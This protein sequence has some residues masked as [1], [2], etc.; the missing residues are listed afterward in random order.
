ML[1]RRFFSNSA[2][3]VAGNA[4]Y[5]LCQWAMVAILAK[6]G[7]TAAVGQFA[8]G[9]AVAAPVFLFANLQ[10]RAL[11]TTDLRE[12]H[13]FGE[14]LGLRLL[15]S[16]AA[17]VAL[18]GFVYLAGYDAPLRRVILAV[19]LAKAF[20][21][22]SDIFHGDLQRRERM[23]SVARYLILKGVLSVA[24]IGLAFRLTGSVEMAALAMAAV[25]A[26]VL[27]SGET[28]FALG[29]AKPV[30][31]PAAFRRLAAT[32]LPLGFV[33]MMISVT[34]N[35]PRYFVEGALG[36]KA[37]G[38]FAALSY[39]GIA[40]TTLVNAVGLAATPRLARLFTAE[41]RGAFSRVLIRS[42]LL[43]MA[44]G[45][46][47]MA[48]LALGGGP[49]LRLLYGPAYAERTDV[50]IWVMAAASI[51]CAACVFGYGMT[52]ARRFREQV[53]LFFGVTGVAAI[54]SAVLIPR[55]GLAG[56]A[57]GQIVTA[58][59]QLAGSASILFF[60]RRGR[61]ACGT[62]AETQTE[63]PFPATGPSADGLA[64]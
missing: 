53:P 30:W 3:S 44:P 11:Q 54:A 43:A 49:L 37:L 47:G 9:L 57:A 2:W 42:G 33:M 1:P 5:A 13:S 52:A 28:R 18:A 46:A 4:I 36:A 48:L 10:M 63:A 7:N 41:D 16:G 21:T 64:A 14:Y 38:I 59:A 51:N 8:M 60:A 39:L 50:A 34:A 61:A 56:A 22:V 29:P 15:T 27:L 6:A 25:F 35:M 31:N 23:D 26:L 32:A 58:L 40:A 55:Y 20:E 17:Y 45:L 62:G 19:A 12:E 24:A